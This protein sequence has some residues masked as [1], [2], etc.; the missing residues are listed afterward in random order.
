MATEGQT[1]GENP[2]QTE[3]GGNAAVPYVTYDDSIKTKVVSVWCKG[4]GE[5][6]ASYGAVLAATQAQL[7]GKELGAG[8]EL[9]VADVKTGI[10]TVARPMDRARTPDWY[11]YN[12]WEV[13][14]DLLGAKSGIELHGNWSSRMCGGALVTEL[15][16]AHVAYNAQHGTGY[17][18]IFEP[19]AG[20][21]E[22]K[23]CKDVPVVGSTAEATVVRE[24]GKLLATTAYGKPKFMV[25][26]DGSPLAKVGAGTKADDWKDL[27]YEYK[28]PVGLIG[29]GFSDF[30]DAMGSGAPLGV[31]RAELGDVQI[32]KTYAIKG[33]DETR[34]VMLACP[35]AQARA[36]LEKLEACSAQAKSGHGIVVEGNLVS[37][38]KPSAIK[39]V[40]EGLHGKE[41]RDQNGG[42]GA[43]LKLEELCDQLREVETAAA[44]E[45]ARAAEEMRMSAARQLAMAAEIERIAGVATA[46][47][48]QLEE[49]AG[50]Q[51]TA[52]QVAS[53]RHGVAQAAAEAQAKSAEAMRVAQEVGAAKAAEAAAKTNEL[54]ELNKQMAHIVAE[55][56]AGRNPMGARLAGG[57]APKPIEF[58]TAAGD[59]PA[60][61]TPAAGVA[62]PAASTPTAGA[63][64][65]GES[66]APNPFLTPPA[67]APPPPPG[68]SVPAE[69]MQFE[70]PAGSAAQP[71]ASSAGLHTRAA[72]VETLAVKPRP[73]SVAAGGRSGGGATRTPRGVGHVTG[74]RGRAGAATFLLCLA[75]TS[76]MLPAGSIEACGGGVRS[77]R[78]GGALPAGS[79]ECGGA[80][81]D[82][83]P[84]WFNRSSW[85]YVS[86]VSCGAELRSGRSAGAT[87]EFDLFERRSCGTLLHAG[88]A[89]RGVRTDSDEPPTAGWVAGCSPPGSVARDAS[90]RWVHDAA[91]CALLLQ[92]RRGA[93]RGRAGGGGLERRRGGAG[94]GGLHAQEAVVGCRRR[95]VETSGVVCGC[96]MGQHRGKEGC[97]SSLGTCNGGKVEGAGRG[98]C[99][100]A[101]RALAEAGRG[102]VD[103]RVDAGLECGDKQRGRA[104]DRVESRRGGGLDSVRGRGR[105]ALHGPYDLLGER[106]GR[107]GQHAATGTRSLLDASPPPAKGG[108]SGGVQ[109]RAGQCGLAGHRRIGRDAGNGTSGRGAAV[110]ARFGDGRH[111]C[112]AGRDDAHANGG[113][114]ASAAGERRRGGWCAAHDGTGSGA[115]LGREAAVR[116]VAGGGAPLRR[117]GSLGGG[118]RCGGCTSHARSVEE[119]GGDA[120]VDGAV[121]ARARPALRGVARG[122]ARH[123]PDG[124]ACARVSHRVLCVGGA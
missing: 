36:V 28:F 50:A 19:D 107:S 108:R 59:G 66:G 70:V 43:K 49:A 40:Y 5:A 93:R 10:W 26:P 88:F 81:T 110:E 78:G 75:G 62:A 15:I 115:S 85:V 120:G 103:A 91:R 44:D 114:G 106:G 89:G 84:G 90:P 52:E 2:M 112:G 45:R 4:T 104:G 92:R 71:V 56:M 68:A 20:R 79:P 1:G 65:P 34:R 67:A 37:V 32:V 29:F 74:S 96:S 99:V 57:A 102:G 64:V 27:A 117:V 101:R 94:R 41:V 16:A 7:A 46:L 61:S 14:L 76:P 39:E 95:P 47:Q 72:E 123:D 17:E 55:C 6:Y 11:K 48:G 42:S 31:L 100:S 12:I 38:I 82:L 80:R 119:R 97:G 13:N 35:L 60:T 54:Y 73:G 18:V 116:R 3:Q 111:A 53:D 24:M 30:E 58:V 118:V 22:G 77:G 124:R 69:M 8:K 9:I 121:V 83:R 87:G 109:V 23:R 25:C 122:R 51:R 21:F 86:P 98:G 63:A 105:G 33:F 113:S